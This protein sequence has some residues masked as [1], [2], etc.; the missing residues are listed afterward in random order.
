MGLY[1]LSEN[2]VALVCIGLLSVTTSA[3]V[4]GVRNVA[5]ETDT[6]STQ[7][8]LI[9]ELLN[10]VKLLEARAGLVEAVSNNQQTQF[11]SLHGLIKRQEQFQS[12]V[13]EDDT[14]AKNVAFTAYLDHDISDAAV[15][16]TIV[17]NQILLNE[18]SGYN[19]MAG[20]FIAPKGGL[21]DFFFTV[22][23]RDVKGL[24]A[25]IYAN[26]TLLVSAAADAHHQY[27]DL[28]GSNRAFVILNKGDAVRVVIHGKGTHV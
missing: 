17:F 12:Q 8:M 19:E 7:N 10:R 15:D 25:S 5:S 4:Q 23:Q 18:G 13:D 9:L 11:E 22:G 26:D 3:S 21:Y 27:Q 20:V 16:Q 24:W 28:Q 1:F 6:E 14:P 2:C